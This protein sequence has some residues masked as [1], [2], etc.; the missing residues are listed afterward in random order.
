MNIINETDIIKLS[1]GTTG[2][3]NAKGL[4]RGDV[5]ASS[6]WHKHGNGYHRGLYRVGNRHVA[7]TDLRRLKRLEPAACEADGT[8]ITE[9]A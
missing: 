3:A 6:S 9:M 1:D 7:G 4:N 8:I 2:L 5:V